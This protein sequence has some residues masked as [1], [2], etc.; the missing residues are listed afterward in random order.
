M[1]LLKYIIPLVVMI[2]I[3]T[4]QIEAQVGQQTSFDRQLNA[5]DDQPVREFVESK[6]NIDI[7][8]KAQNL[9]I[10]GDVRF[11]WRS[12]QE[13][14]E[15]LF[16]DPDD[17]Y[18]DERVLPKTF[19]NFRGGGHVDPAGI[20]L[21]VNDFDVEF[22]LKVQYTFKDAWMKAHLQFDNPAGSRAPRNCSGVYPV[23]NRNGTLVLKEL[24]RDTRRTLKGSGDA[25]FINLRRAFMGYNIYADG[26]NRL[27]IEI[28]RQK[29]SDIF[30]SEVEFTNR[31]DGI[32]LRYA[33]AVEEIFDWYLLG[34]AF[35]IDE[36]VNH[37]GYA[38]EIGF[39]D[40]YETG[41][42]L[43]YNI[44]DWKK[45]GKNRCLIFNPLG[46]DFLNSQVTLTY[47]FSRTLCCKEIP[48]EIYGGFLINHA[49]KKSKFTREKKKNLAWFGGIYIGNVDKKG[50][51]S[52]DIEYV[53]VQAQAVPDQDVGSIGRGNILDLNLV[54]KVKTDRISSGSDYS[55][56][57]Y[58]HPSSDVKGFVPRRGNAN[59]VGWRFEFLYALTDNFSIDF[60]Y[61][62]SNEE[63]KRIGG[64]NFYRNAGIEV[65]YAF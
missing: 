29:L 21:S 64:R 32:L 38:G 28:G 16:F 45:R 44:I 47:N 43:R 27:D 24:P 46:T 8:D 59:F 5:R 13:K 2:G 14:G 63:D 42:D 50:D 36:R 23:Y 15:V 53:A 49:A 4:T 12:L 31:F 55:S 61:E 19:R 39:L 51:W 26:K 11:E 1:K 30:D 37:F 6:E 3:T 40:I 20:P 58:D 62:F 9:E 7:K 18:A 65:I 25:I 22:N 52:I 48:F 34:G 33:S 17:Y 35:V 54:D 60:A 57:S 10:S 56:Y 41:I